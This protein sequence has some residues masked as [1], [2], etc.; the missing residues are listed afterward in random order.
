MT[1]RVHKPLF[2]FPGNSSCLLRPLACL[3]FLLAA[4]PAATSAEP[5]RSPPPA[6]RAPTV[7]LMTLDAALVAAQSGGRV[8]LF[9]RATGRRAAEVELGEPLRGALAASG[10][11]A[12]VA[13]ERVRV[14]SGKELGRTVELASPR[15]VTMGRLSLSDDGRVAAALYPEDGGAGDPDCV[16]LYETASGAHRGTLHAGRGRRFLGAALSASG[17]LLGAF[18][19]GAGRG[20]RT[21]FLAVRSIAARPSSTVLDWSSTEDRTTY[22]AAF[23]PRA[24]LLAL[25]AGERLLL[26][27]L[28]RRRL[29]AAAPTG[30][31]LVLLPKE[32]A[33]QGKARF[34]GVHQV[35]FSQDGRRLATLHAFGVVGVALW[36]VSPLRPLAF[37]PRPEGGGTM[38]QIAF[39]RRGGLLLLTSSTSPEVRVHVAR[40][41]RFVLDRVLSPRGDGGAP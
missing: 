3:L 23:S 6:H 32:L 26:F 1:Q 16:G 37:L 36:S 22:S 4:L 14:L 7:A 25:G 30:A 24:D 38:R 27:D 8:R 31:L 12:L 18:G 17:A 20:G 9:E 34:P 19:D 41:G 10:A 40:G 5:R 33:A 11:I 15:V 39:D 13:D 28:S 35:V 29:S 2:G 21:A